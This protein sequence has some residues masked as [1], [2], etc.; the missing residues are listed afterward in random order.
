MQVTY[1]PGYLLDAGEGRYCS[2]PFR[3]VCDEPDMEL[4]RQACEAAVKAD[5]AVIFAGLP[6]SYETEGYDRKHLRIPVV[7]SKCPGSPG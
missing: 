1:A 7:Q 4:I 2:H 5:R 6:E 3:S